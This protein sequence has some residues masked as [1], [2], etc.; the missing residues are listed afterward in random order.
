MGG[1]TCRWLWVAIG[2]CLIVSLAGCAGVATGVNAAGPQPQPAAVDAVEP[3]PALPTTPDGP[4]RVLQLNLCNSG[5]AA[6]YTGG[7]SITEAAAVIRTETPD[8]ITLNEICEEDVSTLERALAR[9]VTGGAVTSAFQAARDRNTGEAYRCSNGQQ[10]GNGV[11][12]RWP[13]APGSSTGGGIFPTQ[14]PE[15]PEERSWVCLDAAATFAVTVCT[16]H[17]AYTDRQVTVDQCRYLFDTVIGERRAQ[18]GAA[19]LV[20]GGDLNVGS[21]DGCLPDDSPLVDDG[22]VQ[23]VVATPEFVVDSSRLINLRN[24]D[25]PGLL[26]RFDPK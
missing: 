13:L 17:L 23:H 16:T 25:H 19:P 21:G 22:E 14:D 3:S 10:F 8:L 24:T 20:L 9:A 5:I 7:E 12:S 26:V 4:V 6:C 2:G 1:R 11:V 15:D 18:N